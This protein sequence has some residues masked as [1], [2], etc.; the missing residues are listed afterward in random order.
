MDD[1]GRVYI[2][3][4]YHGTISLGSTTLTS[5]GLY[6]TF[7]AQ[8]GTSGNISYA[9]GD[10]GPQNDFIEGLGVSSD[11]GISV[12]GLFPA[13]TGASFGGFALPASGGG[14]VAKLQFALPTAAVDALPSELHSESIN[15]HW[16]GLPAG[17]IA[18][19]TSSPRSMTV[20]LHP[21][22]RT[23]R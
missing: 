15:V 11:G 4:I 19:T 9:Q 22:S 12:A 16:S 2:A 13:A 3:G 10:G 1:Q 5:R 21:G 17:A 6:D 7:L 8:I 14:F 20:R 18:A 23:R